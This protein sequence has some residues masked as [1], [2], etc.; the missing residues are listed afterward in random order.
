[1]D[2]NAL[3]LS[4]KSH[5]NRVLDDLPGSAGSHNTRQEILKLKT[6]LLS[7]GNTHM[8]DCNGLTIQQ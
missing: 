4:L 7:G 2:L 6:V 5:F 1:M 3:Q 8:Q